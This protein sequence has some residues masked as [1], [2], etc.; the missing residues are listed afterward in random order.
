M[1]VHC[2]EMHQII[3][4]GAPGRLEQYIQEIG[5]AGRD[6]VLSQAIL[7][8]GNLNQC[9]EAS[10]KEYVKNTTKWRRQELFKTFNMYED[11][12]SIAPKNCYDL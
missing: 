2:P 7:I 4:M 8:Q 12:D 5:C 11:D 6:G 10:M 9:T 3:H 1:G